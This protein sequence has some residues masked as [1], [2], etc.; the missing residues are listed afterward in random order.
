MIWRSIDRLGRWLAERLGAVVQL[1]VGI[2]CVVASVPLV[3]YGPFSG[4]PPIVYQ[5]SAVAI[6]L[7]GAGLVISA[8]VLLKQ[9]QQD[10]RQADEIAEAVVDRLRSEGVIS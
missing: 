10:E 1:R 3:A 9:E 7:T 6:T 5:M 4:E 2:L 8:Q